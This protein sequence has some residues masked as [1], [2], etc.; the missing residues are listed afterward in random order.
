MQL[1]DIGLIGLGVM[2][3]NLALNI[4]EKGYRVAVYD[5][6]APVLENFYANAGSLQ[7]RIIPCESMEKLCENIAKPRPIIMLIKAGAPVDT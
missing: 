4:A 1:A 3:S 6:E 5:R 7:E 2:G